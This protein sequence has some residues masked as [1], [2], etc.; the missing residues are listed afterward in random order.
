[1]VLRELTPQK[2]SCGW[3]ACPAIFEDEKN[4]KYLLI[5]KVV[6]TRKHKLD[7]RVGKG[8]VLVEIPKGLLA[9]IKK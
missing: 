2:F 6:D 9:E 7:M 1:M 3:G 4:K 8:E 5:G